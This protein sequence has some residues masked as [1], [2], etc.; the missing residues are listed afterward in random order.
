MRVGRS[1]GRRPGLKKER[2]ARK[3][4]PNIF[5]AKSY[6]CPWR[7]IFVLGFFAAHRCAACDCT[8]SRK[9][10]FPRI[11]ENAFNRSRH[12]AETRP[13]SPRSTSRERKTAWRSPNHARRRRLL[14]PLRRGRI[15]KL[16]KNRAISPMPAAERILEC[17]AMYQAKKIAPD[18]FLP[19]GGRPLQP[20]KCQMRRLTRFCRAKR[21]A[22]VMRR[23]VGSVPRAG[24]VSRG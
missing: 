9:F 5:G 6:K 22:R 21:P 10:R 24:G 8:F 12:Q 18:T 1:R 13:A 2:C 4:D 19:P 20:S 23:G 14:A 3:Q 17:C 16:Q 15:T 11:E 7:P